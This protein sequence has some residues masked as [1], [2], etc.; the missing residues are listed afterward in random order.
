MPLSPW[1]SRTCHRR[2]VRQ[3]RARCRAR[4]SAQAA[5]RRRPSPCPARRRPCTG[6][7]AGRP[8]T[9]CTHSHLRRVP[10]ER[11]N[12]AVPPPPDRFSSLE[13]SHRSTDTSRHIPAVERGRYPAVTPAASTT[14]RSRQKSNRSHAPST[15]SHRRTTCCAT[16]SSR[17]RES[18]RHRLGGPKAAPPAPEA[19]TRR[20]LRRGSPDP[21]ASTG[22]AWSPTFTILTKASWTNCRYEGRGARAEAGG[23]LVGASTG[24]A[25]PADASLAPDIDSRLLPDG[26]PLPASPRRGC[27]ELGCAGAPE[28]SHGTGPRQ[29]S[30]PARGCVDRGPRPT[31]SA[32]PRRSKQGSSTAGSSALNDA[33]ESAVARAVA[34]APPNAPRAP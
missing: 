13:H 15:G 11:V 23:G 30:S 29:R 6:S 3:V 28:R 5:C 12:G 8:R 17:T 25:A 10:G 16:N 31:T 34:L 7:R 1:G 33:D 18:S 19:G 27:A 26:A 4:P 14:R 32:A 9:R 22:S 2:A 24:G 20:R 21:E